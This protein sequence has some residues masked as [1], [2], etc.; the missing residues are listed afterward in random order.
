MCGVGVAWGQ[1]DEQPEVPT[2][3]EAGLMAIAEVMASAEVSDNGLRGLEEVGILVESLK[4][5]GSRRTGLTERQLEA[6]LTAAL[7]RSGTVR[8]TTDKLARATMYLNV[9]LMALDPPRGVVCTVHL[10]VWQCAF[11]PRVDGPWLWHAA[12]VT[13]DPLG[14]IGIGPDQEVAQRVKQNVR[15]LVDEFTVEYFKENPQ[16]G[17]H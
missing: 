12:A 1:T 6:T 9:Q 11:L 13:W 16:G 7:L 15:D 5:E 3:D 2:L 4:P 10:K 14:F 8:V 17:P